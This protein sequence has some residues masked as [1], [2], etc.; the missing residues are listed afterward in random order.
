MIQN[1]LVGKFLVFALAVLVNIDEKIFVVF[2]V[3]IFVVISLDFFSTA[4]VVC[5]LFVSV[6]LIACARVASV[7]LAIGEKSKRK[8]PYIIKC[9]N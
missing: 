7:G 6:V 3:V 8:L 2:A 9:L 5:L 1:L 4:F